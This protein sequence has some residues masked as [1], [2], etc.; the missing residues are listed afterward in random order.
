MEELISTAIKMLESGASIQDIRKFFLRHRADIANELLAEVADRVGISLEELKSNTGDSFGKTR[1][2]RP[3]ATFDIMVLSLIGL[4]LLYRR[5]TAK[6]RRG[7]RENSTVGGI[8]LGKKFYKK[9]L[10]TP[11]QKAKDKILNARL[12]DVL[13]GAFKVKLFRRSGMFSKRY[14]RTEIMHVKNIVGVKKAKGVGKKFMFIPPTEQGHGDECAPFEGR[15]WAIDSGVQ[16][17]PYHVNCKHYVKYM[18][19][20]PEG[21]KAT[22]SIPKDV[23]K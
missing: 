3:R 16:L 13:N 1:I 5:D 21:K 9:W 18:D 12:G 23:N 17:P 6:V 8:K 10:A 7:V 19:K 15:Y 2:Q 14:L 20:L 11:T 4:M 22:G